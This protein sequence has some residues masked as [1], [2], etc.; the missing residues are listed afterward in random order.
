MDCRNVHSGLFYLGNCT[1]HLDVAQSLDLCCV[2]AVGRLVEM[3]VPPLMMQSLVWYF[4]VV[5]W[6]RGKRQQGFLLEW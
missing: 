4:V 5:N 3:V 6:P 1:L 2:L